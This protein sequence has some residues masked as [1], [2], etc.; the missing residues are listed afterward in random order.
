MYEATYWG[1]LWVYTVLY[2]ARCKVGS[3]MSVVR[4]IQQIYC[5]IPTGQHSPLQRSCCPV[6]ALQH[7]HIY[8][9][10][11]SREA[12]NKTTSSCTLCTHITEIISFSLKQISTTVVLA[13]V[14]MW[15]VQ[16]DEDPNL[17]KVWFHDSISREEVVDLLTH[18]EAPSF[19]LCWRAKRA[20][21][22]VWLWEFLFVCEG[23]CTCR[24]Y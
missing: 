15:C 24:M 19:S 12:A 6:W 3:Y 4:D 8:I 2:P 17:G 9:H 11:Y 20:Y 21:L 10:T 22:V 18:S 13:V 1:V 16:T 7:I 5:S 14:V 23:H